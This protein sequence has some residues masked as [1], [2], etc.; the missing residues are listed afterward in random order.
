MSRARKRKKPTWKDV[1]RA[2][3]PR[4]RNSQ[5]LARICLD[6]GQKTTIQ[7]RELLHARQPRCQYCGGPLRRPETAELPSNAKRSRTSLASQEPGTGYDSRRGTAE[8]TA[9]SVNK[10]P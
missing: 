2:S 5:P 10:L 3:E 4:S 9:E 6:C 7:R 8:P 1:Y